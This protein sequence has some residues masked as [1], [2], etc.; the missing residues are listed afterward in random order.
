M[1]K[2]SKFKVPETWREI[3]IEK[4]RREG[5]AEGYA[6]GYDAA[7]YTMHTSNEELKEL[8]AH[9]MCPDCNGTGVEAGSGDFPCCV[10][11]GFGFTGPSVDEALADD[12][13]TEDDEYNDALYG[14]ED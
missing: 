11:G 6:W 10:C 13:Y 4:A 3:E 14:A 9:F 2:K 7:Q 5:R 1:P 8:N 12:E